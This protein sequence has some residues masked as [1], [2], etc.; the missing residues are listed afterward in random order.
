M[1]I[2]KKYKTTYATMKVDT[3]VIE[4]FRRGMSFIS[5]GGSMTEGYTVRMGSVWMQV[6][7]MNIETGELEWRILA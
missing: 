1:S 4:E 7:D 2:P 3:N 5:Q 6:I